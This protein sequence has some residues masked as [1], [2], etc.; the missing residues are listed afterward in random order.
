[1][2]A[3]FSLKFQFTLLHCLGVY[4]PPLSPP[5]HGHWCTPIT[6]QILAIA[7]FSNNELD[8]L[9]LWYL[10]TDV[11]SSQ[12]QLKHGLIWPQNTS[13]LSIWDELVLAE[14]GCVSA[15]NWYMALSLCNT[16][17]GS[18]SGC[19]GELW[20]VKCFV[21]VPLSPCGYIDCGSVM[22]SHAVPPEDP[23]VI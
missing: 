3:Y 11:I 6:S 10:E 15:W 9:Y 19:S 13:P 20:W 16:V 18:I 12:K 4:T 21:R 23:Q 17:S 1:M 8:G 14:L 7:L 22:V 5:L 2:V